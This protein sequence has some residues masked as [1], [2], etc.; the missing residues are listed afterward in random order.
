MVRFYFK[1]Q[2]EKI[3]GVRKDNYR[4][5]ATFGNKLIH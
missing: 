5:K 4:N 1:M 3:I 2:K